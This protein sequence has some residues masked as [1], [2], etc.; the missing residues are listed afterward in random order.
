MPTRRVEI[1]EG[2]TVGGG[3]PL[4]LIAGPDMVESEA[5]A[6]KMAHALSEIASSRP[7]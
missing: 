7:L 3:A 2:V 6:L 5:H 1:T 4:L